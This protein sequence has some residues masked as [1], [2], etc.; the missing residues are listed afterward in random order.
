M[1]RFDDRLKRFDATKLSAEK[2]IDLRILH[3][4]IRKDLFEFQAVNAFENN[5]MVYAQAIDLNVYIKRNFAPLEERVRSIITIENQVPNIM[6]AAK[7]NLAQVLP[8]PFVELAIQ[9]ARG[10]ADFLKKDLVEALKDLKDERLRAG[11]QLANRKAWTALS[12]YA[13]WLEKDRLPKAI[14]E[15]PL[16]EQKYR[17]MLAETELLSMEPA[18]VLEIG[19]AE[20]AREQAAFEAAAKVI[21]ASRPAHEVFK[22]VKKDHPTS[23]GLI[24]DTAKTSR[25][26]AN[27]W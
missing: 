5:P 17:Q 11:F 22:E 14:A 27:S 16:G 21:D 18:K 3:A 26:F 4:A 13:N 15:W 19:M 8:R 7:T 9:I 2:A 24:P 1:K 20:L 10:N 23:E 12:D 25:R 6:I